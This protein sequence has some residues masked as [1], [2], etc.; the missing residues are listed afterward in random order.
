VLAAETDRRDNPTLGPHLPV[1]GK[2]AP[3]PRIILGAAAT[4][5]LVALT[6]DLDMNAQMAAA[7]RAG[8]GWIKNDAVC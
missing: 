8:A 5:Q 4:S 2:I 3:D 1:T 6:F 7:A